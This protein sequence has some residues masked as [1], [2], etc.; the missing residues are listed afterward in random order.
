[1]NYIKSNNNDHLDYNHPIKIDESVWWVGH[2]LPDDPFQCHVYLID[3]GESSVLID[4][5]SQLTFEHTLEKIEEIMPFGN[6]KY[7]IAHHQDP[8]I[9]GALLLI[10]GIVDRDDA[11]ILSHWRANA[12][13]KHYDLSIPLECVEERGWTLDLPGRSLEFIF[14]PYLHF[15]GAFATYDRK[16]RTLFSSDLF[17]G[18]TSGWSFVA[19]DTGY[20]DSMRLFHEHYMPSREILR[21]S[22]AKFEKYRIDRIAPQHGSVIPGNL[23]KPIIRKLKDLECGIFTLAG[24]STDVYRLSELNRLLRDS[25]EIIILKHDICEIK[26]AL[27]SRIKTLLPLKSIDFYILDHGGAL[28]R[29]NGQ[30]SGIPDC[31]EVML[32]PDIIGLSRK[33]WRKQYG[34]RYFLSE[35]KRLLIPLFST[36]TGRAVSL[37]LM[38]LSRDIVMD[39]GLEDVIL[40][41]AVPLGVAVERE[42]VLRDVRM[43]KQKF[44]EQAIKDSLTGLY[45][46]LYMEDAVNRLMKIHDRN[47]SASFAVIMFDID[48]FKRVNDS[49]GHG[50]G[51]RVLHVVTEVI[52]DCTREE[53]INVRYGGEEFV[54]FI[55][56]PDREIA[57]SIAERV[58]KH[59]SE[60]RFPSINPELKITISGGVA[61]RRQSESLESVIERS[62]KV[63][64]RAKESGRNRI[65][66]DNDK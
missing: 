47:L 37:A 40:Q 50:A 5:G 17:G 26:N 65:M 48:Y 39:E 56:A 7:F 10:D 53:D 54:S 3:E 36:G 15:P 9:T 13:L 63:L 29:L 58:R 61:Y 23:V 16:S 64:Y 24:E 33:E 18:F 25:L 51:D 62:D 44:Y 11:V 21:H 2:Y 59:V 1:M 32:D 28:I 34:N 38:S 31:P 20:F 49:Y 14:T 45:T 22:L 66:T 35:N 19:E 42:V 6:I 43:D 57:V 55:T 60:L 30:E 52:M 46:R 12:L 41:I 8:D 4:P 27:D